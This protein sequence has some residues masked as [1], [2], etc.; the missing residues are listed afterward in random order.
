MARHAQAFVF[1]GVLDQGVAQHQQSPQFFQG[2]G[3]VVAVGIVLG[4]QA[5]REI[6]GQLA[7]LLV[8]HGL[9][10]GLLVQGNAQG[11]AQAGDAGVQFHQRLFGASGG[12]RQ[13]GR[14]VHGVREGR[15]SGPMKKPSC[16]GLFMAAS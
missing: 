12:V 6:R 1:N 10:V 11:Q 9:D 14:C 4:V 7:M 16:D 15:A 13:G 5:F 8:Q 3:P 2:M